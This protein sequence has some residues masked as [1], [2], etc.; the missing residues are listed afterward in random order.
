MVDINSLNTATKSVLREIAK[1]AYALAIG[2]QN[3]APPQ[4]SSTVPKSVQYLFE[5]SMQL[6]KTSDE[7]T[8]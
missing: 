1:Q 4:E 6:E 2:L 5:T 8:E 7:I 3:A